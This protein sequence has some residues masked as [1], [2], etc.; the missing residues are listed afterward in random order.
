MKT[1]K[2]YKIIFAHGMILRSMSLNTQIRCQKLRILQLFV[3]VKLA[4]ITERLYIIYDY[5]FVSAVRLKKK[6]EY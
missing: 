4:S 5:K 1:M 6:I 2:H 3:Y